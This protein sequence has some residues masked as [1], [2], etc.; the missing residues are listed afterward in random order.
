MTLGTREGIGD[1]RHGDHLRELMGWCFDDRALPVVAADLVQAAARGER[2]N[3]FFVN[4]HCANV[5]YRDAAYDA[6]LRAEPVLFAD[7]VGMRI[8]SRIAQRPLTH[9]VNG[10]D[11]FDELCLAAA[12]AGVS[13]ALL[14]AEPGTTARCVEVLAERYP[15][16][17]VA[18][19]AHGYLDPAAERDALEALNRSGAGLL[20]V[21]KGVPLQE[22]WIAAQG[23]A[24]APPVVLGVGALLDFVAGNVSR[25]PALVRRLSLEWIW[26]LAQEPRRLFERY[27]L[28][29]PLF[30][31]RVL[32]ARLRGTL[33]GPDWR[34][35]GPGSDS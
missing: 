20:F 2:R 3:V 7:G 10:T 18:W 17:Q 5:A 16:L 26:R 33:T 31:L 32:R 13:I 28:G 21:A 22:H 1:D 25:A 34:P 24:L 11:L 27:V 6:L 23:S 19:H 14:G 30:L 4:A 12:E 35:R 15:T 9:N 29:N 8:A